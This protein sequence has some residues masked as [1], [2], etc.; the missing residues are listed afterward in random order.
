MKKVYYIS[1]CCISWTFEEGEDIVEYYIYKDSVFTTREEADRML[2]KALTD[3][4]AYEN[5]DQV[6]YEVMNFIVN[7]LSQNID[8]YE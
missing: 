7:P 5:Y 1:A 8:P 2:E 4:K 3:K 6:D